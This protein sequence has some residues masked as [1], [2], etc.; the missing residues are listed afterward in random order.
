MFILYKSN[1][2]FIIIPINIPMA[3][4]IENNSEMYVES[5]YTPFSQIKLKNKADIPQS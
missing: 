2:R 4:L 1:N 5:Q 3:F